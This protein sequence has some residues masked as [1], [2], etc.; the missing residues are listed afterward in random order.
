[1]TMTCQRRFISCKE[2]PTLAGDVDDGRPGVWPGG[3]RG[4]GRG[5][6]FNVSENLKLLLK[7]KNK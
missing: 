5:N 6:L 3:R 1:M 7:N 4:R 2:G